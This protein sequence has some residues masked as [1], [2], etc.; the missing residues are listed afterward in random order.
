VCSD[1]RGFWWLLVMAGFWRRVL[2]GSPD[3]R[4]HVGVYSLRKRA[5]A[6]GSGGRE[7][8]GEAH[9]VKQGKQ[10][11]LLS[12]RCSGAA[13]Q[14]MFV[15]ILHNAGVTQPVLCVPALELRAFGRLEQRCAEQRPVA[16]A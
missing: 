5:L 14:R 16:V 1:Q 12:H 15:P 11:C 6:G 7:E 10:P 4:V 13:V 3:T 9:V 2:S 8:E